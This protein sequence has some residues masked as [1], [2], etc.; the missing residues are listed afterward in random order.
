MANIA[1]GLR[2]VHTNLLKINLP[3]QTTKKIFGA[4][5]V[6]AKE[7]EIYE[8]AH[9]I[10]TPMIKAEEAAEAA[11]VASEVQI[12]KKPMPIADDAGLMRAKRR[13]RGSN[14]GRASTILGSDS[15]T[16]G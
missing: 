5:K 4:D 9:F 2:K 12:N 7:K 16:L 14:R 10:G 8:G 13:R 1:K 15:E 6:E 11:K 3:F